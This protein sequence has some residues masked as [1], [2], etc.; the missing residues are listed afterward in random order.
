MLDHQIC[1]QR[2]GMVIIDL[3]PFFERHIIL[4]FIII[5]VVEDSYIIREGIAQPVGKCGLSRSGSPG[6]SYDHNI[7]THIVSFFCS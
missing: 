6:D 1:F 4:T 2:I 5:I 3:L 7:I